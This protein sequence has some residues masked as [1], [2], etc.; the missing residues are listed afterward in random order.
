MI[1]ASRCARVS[2]GTV[3]LHNYALDRSRAQPWIAQGLHRS[4]VR[5]ERC[6][7]DRCPV[8]IVRSSYL[9]AQAAPL[10]VNAGW[11]SFDFDGPGSEWYDFNTFLPI[12]F[13]FTQTDRALLNVVD[14]GL[15]G[16]RF[17]V[18]DGLTALGMTSA[19]GNGGAL[20]YSD[21][22][23]AAFADALWSK[24]TFLLLPGSYEINGLATASPLGG[25][26]GAVQLTV[27]PVPGALAL[28]LS[29]LAF[30]GAA[31]RRR[32]DI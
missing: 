6:L 15:S 25:G 27:V 22:F 14:G 4:P 30:A 18:F 29:G 28:M 2:R 7:H 32:N 10:A 24:A 3:A 31:L 26:I 9:G 16:D 20:S 1:P 12:S 13:T 23:D 8:S 17:Q 21:D 5:P 19:P 11:S